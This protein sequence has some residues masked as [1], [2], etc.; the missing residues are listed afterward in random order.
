MGKRWN[1]FFAG[2]ISS[3]CLIGSVI[4]VSAKGEAIY[5]DFDKDRKGSITLY[6][7]VSNDNSTVKTNGS[8][9]SNNVD[10]QLE[11][12]QK[13]T[14]NYKMLPEKGVEF[15]YIKIADAEQVN[16]STKSGIYYTNMESDVLDKFITYGGLQSA[17]DTAGIDAGK[18]ATAK[19]YEPDQVVTALSKLNTAIFEMNVAGNTVVGTGETYLR[20]K[21]TDTSVAVRGSFASTNAYG[22]TKVENLDTGL[23]LIAEVNWEHKAISKHDGYWETVATAQNGTN[24]TGEGSEYADIASPSSP[25]ILQLPM[26]NMNNVTSGGTTYSAGQGWLYDVSAYPKNGTIGIHKDIITNDASTDTNNTGMDTVDTET[27][28]DYHQTN[29]LSDGTSIDEGSHLTHQIDANIGDTVSQV[30]SAD[31][32][33][34]MDDKKNKVFKITDNMTKGLD[35]KSLDSV[36]FGTD[37][38]NSTNNAALSTDDY[39]LSVANDKKS[40]SIE[41]TANGLAKLDAL[42]TASYLYV[43]FDSYVTKDALIGTEHYD[44]TTDKGE[45]ASATNQNTAKLTYATDRTLEHDYYSNTPKVYTYEIDLSKQVKNKGDGN[46]EDVTFTV[47]SYTSQPAGSTLSETDVKFVEE[48]KGIYRIYNANYDVGETPVNS[49]HADA[50]GNIRIKGLDSRDYVFTETKTMK[51]QQLL[52]EPFTVRLVGH[53]IVDEYDT[54]YED[55]S[56]S[57]AYVWTG[58][59]PTKLS[60]YDLLN[61]N[62]NGA[63]SSGV[64][65]VTVMNN[66]LKLLR[67]GGT[68]DVAYLLTGALILIGAM[69]MLVKMEGEANE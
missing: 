62:Q 48:A 40:F 35:F 18:D 68:G 65:K 66:G 45:T 25:F 21:V 29:Y 19:H 54:K 53:K 69:L 11:A 16:T 57:H 15:S 32:P 52:A 26:V 61:T 39:V 1:K 58:E 67:T 8:S 49:V 38:W 4:P 42:S 3:F 23:Y 63:L 31:V 33:A 56:L 43:K 47:K 12:I 7:Y 51:G 6:K 5:E 24:D 55:G 2:I 14:G 41:L 59:M 9:F 22:K 34:L 30:I 28:C 10:E 60:N 44:Y 50:K 37:G 64:A 13:A 27:L 36:T 46:F 17:T 20:Q